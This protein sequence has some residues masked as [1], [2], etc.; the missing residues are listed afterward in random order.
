MSASKIL[1]PHKAQTLVRC[2]E[3]SRVLALTD[4]TDVDFTKHPK[5]KGAGYLH[6][7][8]TSGFLAHSVLTVS[9]AG[10]PL[11]VL[12][13]E[14]WTRPHQDYGKSKERAKKPFAEKESSRWLRAAQAANEILTDGG[15]TEVVM[16][17]DRECDI[18]EIFAAERPRNGH[19]LVRL[20]QNRRVIAPSVSAEDTLVKT[21]IKEYA[22]TLPLTG[23]REVRIGHSNSQ[24]ERVVR[25][26]IGYASITILPP[27]KTTGGVEI[28]L[29]V[30]RQIAEPSSNAPS[31]NAPS[32]N[33]PSSNAPSSNAPSPQNAGEEEPEPIEWILLTTVP[34]ANV[35]EASTI[36]GYYV[37]RWLIERFHYTLKSGCGIE[38]LQ[39][40]TIT[41]LQNAVATYMLVAWR[42]L[43]L[44]YSARTTP[45]LSC[46]LVL[47]RHE[48]QALY[49][50][51]SP[52]EALPTEP[53]T[54]Q[55]AVILIAR[56]GGFLARKR[57]GAPGVKVLWLGWSRLTDI[58]RTWLA[59]K[60]HFTPS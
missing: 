49:A 36:V 40:E 8:T 52:Q 11:G 59:A 37:C 26:G 60:K 24:Q 50:V 39:L 43:W 16:V 23:E 7:K 18:F 14:L 55:Q 3:H 34:I 20:G 1:A 17:G 5:V 32:S 54:L 48:W 13:A 25:V 19:L 38:K 47:E 2:R 41:R 27:G 4:T 31:S 6:T 21:R 57:D 30:A 29:V 51:S 10:V 46:E 42:L 22:A 58:V 33:A 56:L 44:T 15:T 53:P 35:E 12:S 45:E 28:Q 9:T